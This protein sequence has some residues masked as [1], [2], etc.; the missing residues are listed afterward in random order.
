LKLL[1]NLLIILNLVLFPCREILSREIEKDPPL[2][3]SVNDVRLIAISNNLDIKLARLDSKIKGTELS[4]EEAIFDT[5]LNGEIGYTDDQRKVPSSLS[6]T[7]GLTNNYN[8]GIDKKLRS[9]TDV[10]IDFTNKREWTDS[11][12]VSTNPYHES[13]IEIN[14]TQPIAK[15]FFGLI[16]RGNIEI[17]KYEI[18]NSELDSYIKIEDAII[19]T[20]KA[21]WELVLAQEEFKIKKEILK[22]A[23]RLFNQHRKKLKIGIIETG[24]VLASEANMH[25]RESDLL[26]ASNALETSEEL[27]RVRLNIK[28]EINLSPTDTLVGADLNA[29]LVGSLRLAFKN[30]RDYLSAKNDIEGKKIKLK[31]KSNS[32][33]PQI[34]LKTTFAQNGIDSGYARAIEGVYEDSNPKYYVGIEFSYPLENNEAKSEHKSAKLEKAKAIVSLQKTER[35][36]ISDIDEKFRNL[37]VNKVNISKMERVEN[38]QNGKLRQEEKRFEYGRSSSDTLIRYQEDLLNA[39]LATQ[40]AYLDYRISILEL[41]G[42]ED[43]FLKHVGLEQL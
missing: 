38:L 11:T 21:Y 43:S 22:K 27:L 14:L 24:D 20:E 15:N 29:T 36:I 42:A 23:I 39:K 35:L 37:S 8:I 12:Y 1:L 3:I 33:F 34:D 7:K 13:Q 2:Y 4:Y 41:M 28:N 18:K 40:K 17:V 31:M 30:R 25:S 5:I 26:M 16:D 32:L 9:G 19:L 10:E 6:G